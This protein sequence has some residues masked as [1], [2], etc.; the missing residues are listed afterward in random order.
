[1]S[2]AI[3]IRRRLGS[4]V[5]HFADQ[6]ADGSGEHQSGMNGVTTSSLTQ[7]LG[8]L[9]AGA[10]T[11]RLGPVGPGVVGFGTRVVVENL[12]SGETSAFHLMSS[13]AM[14]LNAN[15]ISVDGPLGSALMGKVAG[16]EV[17]VRTP[18]GIQHLKVLRVF[19]IVDLLTL[20][21]PAANETLAGTMQ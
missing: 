16:D 14:D 13:H 7:H 5:S 19:S 3:E 20:L 9:V 2:S 15:H 17:E 11:E 18:S 6:V 21:E 12:E 10:T 4:L 8:L 1:M